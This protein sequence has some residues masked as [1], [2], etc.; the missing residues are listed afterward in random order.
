M[1][2]GELLAAREAID[3]VGRQGELVALRGLLGAAG[4]RVAHVHGIPGIGK[5]TLLKA[6]AAEAR[7]G[8]AKVHLLDCREVEPTPGG[9]CDALARV[10]EVPPADP[11]ALGRRV[12]A[13]GPVVLLALDGFESFRLLDTWLRLNF[14]P[15]LPSN[16]RVIF[17]GRHRPAVGWSFGGW[18]KLVLN[19]P[20]APLDPE[21]AVAL[22]ESADLPPAQGL[23]IAEALHGHPLALRLAASVLAE[24]PDLDLPDAT[25]HRV[26]SELTPIYLAEVE[27]AGTRRLLEGASVVRRITTPVLASMFT[28]TEPEE[29]YRRLERLAFTEVVCDG[30][31]LHDGVRD[32]IALTLRA[33]D[34]DRHL[35]YRRGAW[36]VLAEQA[37]TAGHPE[38]WR[39]TADMLYLIENPVV[40][41]AFFPSG[42]SQVAVENA[43][44]RDGSDIDAIAAAHEGRSAAD[45][46]MRWWDRYPESFVVVRN[47]DGGCDGFCTRFDPG[48]VERKVLAE[49][50]VVSSWMSHLESDP[51]PEGK[52]A[53]FIRRWLHRRDGERPGDVQAAC[54]LDLKR[55]YM[56]MRPDLRRVYLTVADI[57]PYA[58]VA[59]ELGFRVLDGHAVDMDGRTY[60]SV[61]LD[62]GTDS[63]DG[64]LAGLAAA[65]L[66]MPRE[67]KILDRDARELVLDGR[68]TSLTPLEFGVFAFLCDREG[69]AVTRDDLLREVWRTD[70]TGWSN[71]V[72]A[73]IAGLRHKLGRHAKRIQTVTG[74]GYRYRSDASAKQDGS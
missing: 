28:E 37:S 21:D 31:R 43:H 10:A 3:M 66:G 29:A 11:E 73:V 52:R 23:R 39:Y 16:V 63:V 36:Q 48:E 22:L 60:H 46:L 61:V 20:L 55:T 59:R 32:A 9:F 57:E 69:Q 6:F 64:W 19:L 40:R 65:E 30:L 8:G 68:R 13:S 51:I 45:C 42:T 25:L 17:A 41:E 26:M 67:E 2:V 4:P 49:D 50:P 72:D 27:D 47:A 62:F 74:V 38:L 44:R 34:P 1:K 5:S 56:E 33:R 71:K 14:V 18:E 15:T 54:W 70:Y 35:D 58:A 12:A 7:S 53:L 24:Q